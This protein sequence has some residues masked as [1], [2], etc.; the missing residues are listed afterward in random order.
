MP[1]RSILA[2]VRHIVLLTSI[3]INWE[4]CRAGLLKVSHDMNTYSRGGSIA[5]LLSGPALSDTNSDG[6]TP[7]GLQMAGA[8]FYDLER[9]DRS[10]CLGEGSFSEC[11]VQV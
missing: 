7:D 5:L 2:L 10:H 9:V 8:V 11:L 1:V 3:R 4:S 6:A